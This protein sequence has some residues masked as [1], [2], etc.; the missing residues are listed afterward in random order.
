VHQLSRH[1][2]TQSSQA[3]LLFILCR[4]VCHYNRTRFVPV[5]R[6]RLRQGRIRSASR[7][8][9]ALLLLRRHAGSRWGVAAGCV[10]FVGHYM[11]LLLHK[12]LQ[13]NPNW[14]RAL[15]DQAGVSW[16][17]PGHPRKA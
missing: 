8:R 15:G 9:H 14:P 16:V 3:L 6:P 11:Q 5:L 17:P 12:L 2:V 4:A 1:V 13:R 10:C 7:R